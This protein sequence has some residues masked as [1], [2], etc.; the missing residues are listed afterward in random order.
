[1][2]EA[3]FIARDERERLCLALAELTREHRYEDVQGALVAERARLPSDAF[4]RHFAD[5]EQCLLAAVDAVVEQLIEA[6]GDAYMRCSGDWPEA[7]RCALAVLLEF[8]ANSSALTRLC[9]E[10]GIRLGPALMERRDRLL[11]RFDELLAPG[12]AESPSPPPE[13]VS[14]AIAGSVLALISTGIAEQRVDSLPE[15]LPLATVMALSPFLGTERAQQV[16]GGPVN[17]G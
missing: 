5:K 17:P 4:E 13:V 9:A 11:E 6:V 14:E 8:L 1:M 7:V 2:R 12:Y 10:D 16:A 3:R 15:A